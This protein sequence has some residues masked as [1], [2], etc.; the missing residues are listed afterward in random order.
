MQIPKD[1][2]VLITPKD[3]HVIMLTCMV[4]LLPP[5]AGSR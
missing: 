3:V 5:P 2:E 4:M 1:T